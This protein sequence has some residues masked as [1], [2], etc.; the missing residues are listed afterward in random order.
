MIGSFEFPTF[1]KSHHHG[2]GFQGSPVEAN[3]RRDERSWRWKGAFW[4]PS[5]RRRGGCS[6]SPRADG[7]VLSSVSLFKAPS[8]RISVDSQRTTPASAA[9]V[10]AD[11]T[12][13]S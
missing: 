9:E 10:A 8:S 6:R 3:A 13:P 5:V 4:L 11:A 12:P 2:A 1:S 7:V